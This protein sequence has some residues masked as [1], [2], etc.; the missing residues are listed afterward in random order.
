M[1]MIFKRRSIRKYKSDPV[2]KELI[3]EIIKAGIAAPSAGNQQPWHFI[4]LDNRKI[5]DWIPDNIHPHSKMLKEAPVGILLCG[6]PT[7]EKHKGYWVQDCA[8]CTQ[9]MLLAATSAGLGSVW[10][11]IYPRENRVIGLRQLLGI[12]E[13]VIPF[14]IVALGYA[15][16]EK[17]EKTEFDL[18]GLRYNHW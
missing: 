15:A 16:E 6:D 18:S 4:V 3:H 5:L 7:L 10:L 2:S 1:D 12:P 13:H 8:A 11:G 9:N 17:P 14:S